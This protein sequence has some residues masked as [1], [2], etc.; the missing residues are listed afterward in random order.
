[1]RKDIAGAGSVAETET[2]FKSG[3]VGNNSSAA[4]WLIGISTYLLWGF[5]PLYFVF[6]KDI[7]SLEVI[8]HRSFWSFLTC[9]IV[10][11]AMRNLK[12]VIPLIRNWAILIR[13]ALAGVLIIINWTV[14]VY[15]VQTGH[16]TDAALG[17]FI[18]PLVTVFLG[19]LLLRERLT[20]LQKAALGCGIAAVSYL[21]FAMGTLP[22]ISFV[23][24]FSFGFYAL[25]KKKIS[26]QVPPLAGMVVENAAIL[27]F[28]LGYLGYLLVRKQSDVQ[29][30]A[31]TGIEN[32]DGTQIIRIMLLLIGAGILTAIPLLLFAKASQN[33]PLGALGFIQYITPIL[34]LLI[35]VVILGEVMPAERWIGTGIVWCALI[36]L[37]ADGIIAMRKFAKFKAGLKCESHD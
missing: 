14:Y 37:I 2:R 35:G 19:M 1:M 33:L 11:A 21:L 26:R 28:L 15:S 13:L 36:F 10:L 8:V 31:I 9:V 32:N 7:G 27:P 6:L 30:I 24:A 16:T 34:Q 17:Y 3:A 29:K 22:W 12:S 4:P 18:N 5:F 25:V 23:L 20:V